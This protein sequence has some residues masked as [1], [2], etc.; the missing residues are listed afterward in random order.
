MSPNEPGDETATSES[1]ATASEEPD[2]RDAGAGDEDETEA[3]S[4]SESIDNIERVRLNPDEIVEMLAYNGQEDIG[5]KG[6]VVFSLQ[7]P[8]GETVEPTLRHLDEDSTE[9][10]AEGEINLRPFRLVVEG[11]QVVE[12]RPTRQLAIEELDEDDPDDAAIEAWIDDAMETWKAHVRENLAESVDIFSPHGMT[13]ISVEY[14]SGTE[15]ETGS[16]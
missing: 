5:D 14:E 10:K 12:Q 8:F 6:K 13:I 3:P 4:D 9:S 7:P 15:T 1:D 16:T 2:S 11:R